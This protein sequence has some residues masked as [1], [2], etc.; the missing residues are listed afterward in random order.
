MLKNK[1]VISCQVKAQGRE[2]KFV[3]FFLVVL[4]YSCFAICDL[5]FAQG[6]FVYDQGGRRNPFIPL[7]TPDGRMVQLDTTQEKRTGDL[8]VE[9]II[10]DDSGTSYAVV[11]SQIVKVGDQVQGYEVV[12]IEKN[13][14]VLKKDNSVREIPLSKEEEE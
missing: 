4:Y 14:V 3:M 12:K 8:L 2:P 10:Y 13:K 6:R 5:V 9:G 1:S 11:N 7:I